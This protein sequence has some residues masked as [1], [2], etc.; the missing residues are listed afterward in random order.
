MKRVAV[1][2]GG[3]AGSFA[4]AKLAAAGLE[5]TVI[6][7]KLAWE[8]PCGGGITYKA[9]EKYTFLK[10]NATPKQLVTETVVAAPQAGSA[11]MTL[12]QPLIIY[13]RLDLNG[14]M[15][16]RARSAGAQV[17]KARVTSLERRDKRWVLKTRHGDIDADYCIVATGA[18]NPLRDVG[19]QLRPSDTMIALGYFV[20]SA[21]P[22]IDIQF[23]ER[24]E[25][26]IWVFP[27][28]SHLSV[29]ICGKGETAQKLRAR[30]EAYMR[31]KELDYTK[32]QFYSHLL[33][34]LETPAWRSNR[35]AGDGWMAV[36]DAG[37]L[38]DPITGEG[39]YYA[40][41]SADLATDTILRD[42]HPV[43]E[44]SAAY[45]R[46]LH[47]DF[48]DDLAFG[49]L[50]ARRVFMGKFLFRTVPNRMVDFMRRSPLFLDLMQDLFAGTQP[51]ST[52]RAR[53]LRNL[54]G[55]LGEVFMNMFLKHVIPQSQQA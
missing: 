10:D 35:I 54:H 5:T 41:R 21:Q 16:N 23:L 26:Y 24:L 2:G 44:F 27:R 22:H 50:L 18:R 45:R 52:L 31:A 48:T 37:G 14:M 1:L 11:R 20:P 12:R 30:L 33:P 47:R 53:L 9:Y 3:P 13:S 40:M 7:E 51:Y 34:S 4:A 39:L 8:K 6:D 19:T 15:L 32:G 42:E 46:L 29:G 17:E 55:T 28:H 36:G 43:G 49:A 38:V 25:G